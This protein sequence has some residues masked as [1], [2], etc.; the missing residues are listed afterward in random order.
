MKDI[1]LDVKG[2]ARIDVRCSYSKK[3]FMAEAYVKFKGASPN[4]WYWSPFG[5]PVIIPDP[6][7]L[8]R[9]EHARIKRTCADL[10]AIEIGHPYRLRSKL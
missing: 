5:V 8:N 1:W 9:I 7:G 10:A 2:N 4:T 3:N 6:K